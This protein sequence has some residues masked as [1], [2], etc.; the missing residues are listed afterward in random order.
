MP[1]FYS[2][3]IY[4]GY[5][6]ANITVQD[7]SGAL[8]HDEV[9]HYEDKRYVGSVEA[10]WRLLGFEMHYQ[11]HPVMRLACHMEDEQSVT[12]QRGQENAALN[13]ADANE[14]TLLAWFTLNA[15]DPSARRLLYTEL[16]QNYRFESGRWIQRKRQMPRVTVTRLMT[17]NPRNIELFHLRLL[18]LHTRGA[19]GYGDIRF[20]EGTLYPTFRE[21]AIARGIA[22]SD[23]QW[24]AVMN[25]AVS[26]QM[27]RQC[28]DMFAIILALNSPSNSVEL[29]E[30]FKESLG[31]DFIRNGQ[32]PA[33]ALNLALIEIEDLLKT[34]NTNCASLGL[35]TPDRS[36]VAAEAARGHFE[37][38]VEAARFDSFYRDATQEQKGVMDAL[39]AALSEPELRARV[40]YLD[41]P[42]GCGKT[43]VQRA[44]IS[45]A[46]SHGI[47]VLSSAYTGIAASLM[48]GGRTLHNL[49]KLPIVLTE[50]AT[51]SLMPNSSHAQHLRNAKLI[52]IDEASS[53]PGAALSV[54]DRLLRFLY[55][56]QPEE[57]F[58]FAGKT[59][60]M[61]GD[62][63]QTLP[64]VPRAGRARTVEATLKK[65]PLWRHVTEFSLSRNMRVNEG[66]GAFA[67]YLLT[68]GAGG[69]AND[70]IQLPP[71]L[72]GEGDVVDW[73]YGDIQLA[74]L[75]GTLSD[76]A[77][78]APTNNNCAVIN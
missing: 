74:L 15:A 31:E 11:D 48:E 18:L 51:S 65:N 55:E 6:A 24:E 59:L 34:H 78:L 68:V 35:P 33:G 67:E 42:A 26:F 13:N 72:K 40:F 69:Q 14:S 61:S 32:S 37:P 22:T 44:L 27:P 16:P 7:A 71:Q 4:K 39:K 73:V 60:L 9:K 56:G 47:C 30:Q 36:D 19:E 5:D 17:V 41:A 62:F 70:I 53:V 45:Y 29:W 28:R 50:Q 1:L 66:E 20:H 77:I 38:E 63:R 75:S 76:R 23:S 52:I 64:V 57:N 46:K 2:Q 49:F 8:T 43:Y 10:A 58:P 12:F 21:A 54:I 3:Y 25:K